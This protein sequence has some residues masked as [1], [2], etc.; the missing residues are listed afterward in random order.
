MLLIMMGPT[1]CWTLCYTSNDDCHEPLSVVGLHWGNHLIFKSLRGWFDLM[2]H[3][4]PSM[5]H[6]LKESSY[7]GMWWDTSKVDSHDF[8]SQILMLAI[9]MGPTYYHLSAMMH[10]YVMDMARTRHKHG[11][12]TDFTH[13]KWSIGY[14]T[15]RHNMLPILKYPC[16]IACQ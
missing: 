6:S 7:I 9:T 4:N 5:C 14:Y 2:N 8:L 1:E 10:R 12:D 16:I 3:K 11:K 13:K 15:T